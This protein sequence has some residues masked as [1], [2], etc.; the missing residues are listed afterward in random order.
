MHRFST[1]RKRNKNLWRY[2]KW[3]QLTEAYSE[4]CQTSKIECFV[5]YLKAFNNQLFLQ[6]TPSQIYDRILNQKPLMESFT[7]SLQNVPQPLI[8]GPKHIYD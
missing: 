8:P 2:E 3:Q 6:N 5:K 1:P 4:P 7:T